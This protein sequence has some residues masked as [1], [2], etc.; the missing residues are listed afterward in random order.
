MAWSVSLCH[1]LLVHM[2]FSL[3][4]VRS[5]GRTYFGAKIIP[6]RGAWVEIESEADGVIYVK[7]DRKR[8]FP[9]SSLFRVLGVPTDKEMLEAF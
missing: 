3:Q 8:K 9:I 2:V 7:I 6:A 1:S 5:K 4:Q